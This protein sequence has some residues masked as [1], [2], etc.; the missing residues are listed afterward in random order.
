MFDQLTPIQPISASL[1]NER[2]TEITTRWAKEASK[3]VTIL[4]ALVLC[5]PVRLAD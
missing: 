1:Q 4:I 2:Q 5:A 3:I